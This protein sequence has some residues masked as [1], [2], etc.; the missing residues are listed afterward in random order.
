MSD[1]FYRLEAGEHGPVSF[2]ELAQLL[3]EGELQ[4]GDLVRRATDD[5]WQPAEH[6][7][8]LAREAA[9]LV[10]LA[11]AEAEG[12]S[13]DGENAA[14]SRAAD[15]I[16][17]DRIGSAQDAGPGELDSKRVHPSQQRGRWRFLAQW[18]VGALVIAVCGVSRRGGLAGPNGF[19]RPSAICRCVRLWGLSIKSAFPPP[20][21]QQFRD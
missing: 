7:V 11:V 21:N 6:V 14:A 8:G 16:L 3:A 18:L 20:S 15:E 1:W 2:R 4:D 13:T 17:E 9:K 10:E 19:Q 5:K 12:R